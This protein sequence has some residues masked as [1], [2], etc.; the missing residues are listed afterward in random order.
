MNMIESRAIM[1]GLGEE[2]HGKVQNAPLKYANGSA[3]NLYFVLSA[4][5]VLFQAF[6]RFT[7]YKRTTEM[8]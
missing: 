8:Q 1:G 4:L 6:I 2:Q 5:P 3:E 7:T